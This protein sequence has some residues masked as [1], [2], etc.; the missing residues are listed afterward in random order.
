MYVLMLVHQVHLDLTNC[1]HKS[2]ALK[3]CGKQ[4]C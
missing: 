2:I 4:C 3:E 1:V